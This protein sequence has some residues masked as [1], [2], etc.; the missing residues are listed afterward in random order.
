MT[1]SGNGGR[2]IN[3]N[4]HASPEKEREEWRGREG[5]EG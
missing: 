2:K 5:G 1:A 4:S 3:T